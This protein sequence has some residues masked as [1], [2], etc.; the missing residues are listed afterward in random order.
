MKKYILVVLATLV[1]A[2][3]AMATTTITPKTPIKDASGCYAISEAEELF[4]FAELVNKA[5]GNDDASICAKLMGDIT[6]NSNVL[7]KADGTSNVGEDGSYVGNTADLVEWTPIGT[8]EHPFVGDFYGNGFTI[9]GLFVNDDEMSNVGLFGYVGATYYDLPILFDNVKLVDAYV[10]GLSCVGGLVGYAAFDLAIKNSF[11]ES[12]VEGLIT[13]VGG[14]VGMVKGGVLITNS[15][16]KGNVKSKSA[17]HAGGLVG[18]AG[19][20]LTIMGSFSEGDVGSIL[21]AGGLVGMVKGEALIENSYSKGN[22]K[23]TNPY[24]GGLVGYSETTLIIKRCFSEGNVESEKSKQAGGLVGYTHST[25][26][27]NSYAKGDISAEGYEGNAAVG[28][29]VGYLGKESLLSVKNSYYAGTVST[30]DG[31]TKFGGIVGEIVDGSEASLENAVYLANEG[32]KAYGDVEPEGAIA[33]SQEDFADGTVAVAL[34]NFE[35][36]DKKVDGKI[37][38]QNLGIETPEEFPTLAADGNGKIIFPIVAELNGGSVKEGVPNGYVYGE[39]VVFPAPT[40]EHYDFIGWFTDKSFAKGS[41]I[42]GIADTTVGSVSI[43]AGWCDH[44]YTIAVKTNDSKKGD[45][46]GGDK[47]VYGREVKLSALARDGYKFSNWEDDVNAAAERTIIVKGDSTFTASFVEEPKSSSSSADNS[48]SSVKAKSSSSSVKAKSSSSSVKAKSSSSSVKAKS[49]SSSGKK[50]DAIAPVVQ[51]P[52]FSVIAQQR[53]VQ[54]IGAPVG[55]RFAVFDVQGH[56]A[57]AG[58]VESANFSVNVPRAGG[59]FVRI[60]GVTKSVKIK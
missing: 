54:L 36:S 15:Y 30:S 24:A 45:V 38:G 33:V 19:A 32:Y 51:I 43:Y 29:L 12:D 3:S 35:S 23:S 59:Y 18:D 2:G 6:L 55:A 8:Q 5:G 27:E 37:W 60:N 41:E 22:V 46:E 49:S 14:L 34:H 10:R 44:L 50:K 9:S 25:T 20:N 53:S 39:Q 56:V 42:A 21:A 16:S 26:I 57:T 40:Q 47:Y 28:G 11:L 17:T 52:Q 4:G 1:A 13:Y 7:K 48:S 31:F 58:Q